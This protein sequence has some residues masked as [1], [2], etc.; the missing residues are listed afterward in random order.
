MSIGLHSPSVVLRHSSEVLMLTPRYPQGGRAPGRAADRAGTESMLRDFL[1]DDGNRLALMKL[2]HAVE[3]EYSAAQP[4]SLD[5]AA[6]HVAGL[7]ASGKVLAARLGEP[8]GFVEGA[9]PFNLRQLAYLSTRNGPVVGSYFLTGEYAVR[10][11]TISVSAAGRHSAALAGSPRFFATARLKIDGECGDIQPLAQ[12]TTLAPSADAPTPLGSA[13]WQ[14]PDVRHG[15]SAAL[16]IS[17]GYVLATANGPMTP[18]PATAER[19][20]PLL[21]G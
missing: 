12:D 16:V 21:L 6:R 14:L 7:I 20:F 17:A 13:S 4:R 9:Y 2:C 18:L 5:D 19:E 15:Q 8:A 10:G 3:P 11:R 1:S